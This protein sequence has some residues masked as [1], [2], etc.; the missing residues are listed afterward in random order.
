[1]ET[2]KIALII[3]LI[4]LIFLALGVIVYVARQRAE[5]KNLQTGKISV[6]VGVSGNKAATTTGNTG[7]VTKEGKPITEEQINAKIE[8]TKAQIS[9]GA[10]GRAYTSDELFFISSPRKAAISELQ[11]SQ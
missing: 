7:V 6:P 3:F 5:V 4:A 2:R 11:K 8:A 10:K 9:Q 1:M